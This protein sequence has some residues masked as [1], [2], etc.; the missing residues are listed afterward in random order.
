MKF[1]S[2]FKDK[3]I[4]WFSVLSVI[5]GFIV[6]IVDTEMAG[7]LPRYFTDF[8]YLLL[9]PTIIIIFSLE[10]VIFKNKT[11]RNLLIVSIL[12]ALLYE[13]L[14]LFIDSAPSVKDTMQ[15]LYMYF[16]Y[17]FC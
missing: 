7:I 2:Y 14:T 5:F 8:G 12:L 13:S 4:Y 15:E 10:K 9:I 11:L 17:L 16:Y 3:K 6:I 1:K